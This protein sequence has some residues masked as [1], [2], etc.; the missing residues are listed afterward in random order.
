MLQEELPGVIACVVVGISFAFWGASEV[1]K[2]TARGL[3]TFLV[4]AR[5][6]LFGLIC[7]AICT[8]GLL[9]MLSVYRVP[10][11][12]DYASQ[13]A[14]RPW[15]PAEEIRTNSGE[16]SVGYVISTTDDWFLLM[17]ENGRSLEY[18]SA[19]K[20]VGRLI[21]TPRSCDSEYKPPLIEIRG[22]GKPAGR[23]CSDSVH[24]KS[25]PHT[26]RPP[27][28]LRHQDAQTRCRP[29]AASADGST[30]PGVCRRGA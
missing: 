20:V 5:Y 6:V 13:I 28:H 11:N 27:S 17:N 29:P 25:S 12:V 2:G 22:A 18:V 8:L 9:F 30:A 24:A 14:R 3:D 1:A 10:F 26:R 21:C 19:G 16:E 15:L 4:Q 7:G 23:V